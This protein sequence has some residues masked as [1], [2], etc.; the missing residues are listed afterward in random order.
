MC[1]GIEASTGE[2]RPRPI[3]RGRPRYADPRLDTQHHGDHTIVTL[4]GEFDLASRPALREELRR[5]LETCAG[6]LLVL[7]LTAVGFLDCAALGVLVGVHNDAN[8]QGVSLALVGAPRPIKRLLGITQIDLLIKT[9]PNLEAA[10]SVP[11]PAAGQTPEP[12]DD[13]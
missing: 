1:I 13:G 7:D 8:R 12:S 2:S 5:A 11:A 3:T 4:R 10:L 9:H 6:H